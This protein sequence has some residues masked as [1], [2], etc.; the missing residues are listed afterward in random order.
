V[1]HVQ[2]VQK[3]T[4]WQKKYDNCVMAVTSITEFLGI[5]QH[6]SSNTFGKFELNIFTSEVM[7][8]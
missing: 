4:L 1:A 8:V 2:G 6:R 7:A 3:K 5:K